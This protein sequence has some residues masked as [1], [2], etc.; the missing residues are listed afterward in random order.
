MADESLLSREEIDTKGESDKDIENG[1]NDCRGGIYG[2]VKNA[3][4]AGGDKIGELGNNCGAVKFELGQNYRVFGE[5]IA[6]PLPP[7]L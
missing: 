5:K 6:E 7:N 2:L 4:A 1:R 3:F